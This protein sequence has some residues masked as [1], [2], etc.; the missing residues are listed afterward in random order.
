MP[1]VASQVS[2]AYQRDTTLA[3]R[4][5]SDVSVGI[6]PG[7]VTLV[8]GATGSG[9][10]TL[11]RVL[12]GLLAPTKGE[13]SVEGKHLG[14]GDV[15]LVFQHPESQ[16]FAET[17]LDDVAFG[18]RNLGMSNQAAEAISRDALKKVGLDPDTFGGR[19]PFS[20]SGGQARRAAI[21]GVLAM[22]PRYVLFDEP[23]AGLDA[24]G[25][26]FVRE[27][28]ADLAARGV[29]VVVVTHAAEEFLA[30]ADTLVLLRDGGCTYR[31]AAS[32]AVSDPSVFSAAS[33][34]M[35]AVLEAQVAARELG[36]VLEELSLDPVQTAANLLAARGWSSWR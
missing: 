34:G 24:Q 1:L 11:L 21:A 32:L 15:G 4:A 2:Y 12:A 13:V 5:L 22:Q 7:Q 3:Q 35:P 30:A 31:G 25:R 16:L 29:G 6:E 36:L 8:L 9:K 19:S 14:L 28:V 18:P 20:L 17:V 26:R 23:T 33:L 10:S 27:I